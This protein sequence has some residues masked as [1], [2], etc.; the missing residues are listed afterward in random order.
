MGE[1]KKVLVSLKE[2]KAPRPD[3][4]PVKFLKAFR[5]VLEGDITGAMTEFFQKTSLYRSANAMFLALIPKS[6]ELRS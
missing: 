4:F 5:D 2:D 6:R 1:V 3:G